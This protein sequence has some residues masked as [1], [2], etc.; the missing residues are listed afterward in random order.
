MSKP[1][2]FLT[3]KEA[4]ELSM[5]DMPFLILTDNFHSWFS[6]RT[7]GHTHGHYNHAAFLLFRGFIPTALSQDWILRTKPLSNYMSGKHRVKLWHD[8]D[9]SWD[10]KENML[11]EC[12]LLLDRPF[13]R[14]LYDVVG[15]IGQA[16]R[17]PR[18][19]IPGL[20][21]CSEVT[22]RVLAAGDEDC[23]M[24]HP[25]PADLNRWCKESPNMKCCGVYDPDVEE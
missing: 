24:A 15:L 18:L 13:Y 14:R 1:T 7:K 8:P 2:R 23:G 19:N 25:S 6:W 11:D 22:A 20:F 21:Y 10:Q 17:H 3:R 4:L 5:A 9:W 12:D 16:I